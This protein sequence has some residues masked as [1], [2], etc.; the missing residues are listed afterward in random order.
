MKAYLQEPSKK[1]P[2]EAEEAT[3]APWLDRWAAMS[4]GFAALRP[5]GAR[6][7]SFAAGLPRACLVASHAGDLGGT[8]RQIRGVAA[9]NILRVWALLYSST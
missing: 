9:P 8:H 6:C 4:P 3:G 1:P 2:Y 5:L 7:S